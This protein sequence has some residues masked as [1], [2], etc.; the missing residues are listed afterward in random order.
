MKKLLLS[1]ILVLVISFFTVSVVFAETPRTATGGAHGN[2]GLDL[3]QRVDARLTQLQERKEELREKAAS[4]AGE[5]REKRK[6]IVK[7]FL[8]K[9]LE[10]LTKVVA[11]LDRIAEK[12]QAR[13]NKLKDKGVDVSSMQAGLDGCADSKTAALAAIDAAKL[14]VE[15]IS[16]SGDRDGTAKAAHGVVKTAREAV[17]S[18][19]KCL[20]GVLRQLKAAAYLREGTESAKD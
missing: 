12:I 7:G 10:K 13:I 2:F 8:T 18:Y 6:G 14:K 15:A 5:F 3:R 17:F 4:R 9:A 20:V 19:H 1:P 11:R 16:D